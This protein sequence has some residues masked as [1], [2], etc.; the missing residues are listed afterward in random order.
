M[1]AEEHEPVQTEAIDQFDERQTESRGPGDG[2][3]IEALHDVVPVH[4]VG[5]C[6]DPRIVLGDLVEDADQV[7][8]LDVHH[9]RAELARDVRLVEVE[10]IHAAED[11]PHRPDGHVAEI[12]SRGVDLDDV[13]DLAVDLVIVDRADDDLV[14]RVLAHLA[15]AAGELDEAHRARVAQGLVI[16]RREVDLVVCLRGEDHQRDV[17]GYV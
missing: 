7:I 11:V 13:A 3:V 1:L 16:P 12:P 4:L 6:L 15:E 8:H 17:V 14:A 5:E 9:V 2:H 10:V